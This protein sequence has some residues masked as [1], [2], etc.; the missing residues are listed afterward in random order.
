MTHA[1]PRALRSTTSSS[2]DLAR[3]NDSMNTWT[4]EAIM[5]TEK[6]SWTLSA[7]HHTFSTSS[8]HYT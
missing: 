6:M 3:L 2:P 7:N 5:T 8:T 1:R 4:K